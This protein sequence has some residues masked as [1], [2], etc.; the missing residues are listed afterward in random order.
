MN[1]KSKKLL[2]TALVVLAIFIFGIYKIIDSGITG[3]L[4]NK[5]GDQYLKTVVSLVEMHKLRN[6]TYPDSLSELKYVGDWDRI[7]IQNVNYYTNCVHT[8]YYVEVTRG[9]AA[10][11]KLV[12]EV[13]FWQGT[14]YS[15]DLERCEK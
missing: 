15:E 7:G 10:K 2:F 13:E 4:D 14:G 9:W 6:G 1:N 11:P 12:M 5:F 8:K 3:P